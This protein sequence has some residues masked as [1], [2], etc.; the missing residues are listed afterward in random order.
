[1]TMSPRKILITAFTFP[2]QANGVSLVAWEQARGLAGRGHEVTVATGRD[3]ARRNQTLP[4]KLRV[5]EFDVSGNAVSGY[6]GDVTSYRNYI[7]EFDG[8]AILCHCWQIWSTDLAVTAFANSRAK[9]ILVSHGV[10]ANSTYYFPRPSVS[11]RFPVNVLRAVVLW[12][13][14]R[15]Y[16]W[17]MPKMLRV[18]DHVV[19]LAEK[20]DAD[21]FYDRMLVQR[22]GLANWSVIP[23][24]ASLASL[25]AE[26]LDFRSAYQLGD[27]PLLL[28]V[29]NYEPLKDQIFALR[30]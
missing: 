22:M 10:S 29:A 26:G 1:M 8:D 28:H 14:W 27:V 21:R 15:P 19:F 7:A 24:G 18:F 11:L 2:P 23:N 25:T 20:I 3:P 5:V 16:V 9:K 12:L 30:A 17:R 6:R 4:E 13:A